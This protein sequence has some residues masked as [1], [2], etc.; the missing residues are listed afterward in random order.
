VDERKLSLDQEIEM[1]PR[2]VFSGVSDIAKR[3]PNPQKFR[4]AEMVELMVARSDNTAEETLFRIGGGGSEITARLRRWKIDGVRVDRSER[5]CA[6]DMNGVEHYP[7]PE[8]WTDAGIKRLI[9]AVP[10]PVR[11]KT[12]LKGLKDPRDT[13][14]PKGTVA[15]F[16][17]LFRGELLSR[18]SSAF[19]IDILKSTVSFPTR[20][21]GALPPGT[22][23][24]HKTGSHQN[25]TSFTA[26]T[27]DSGVIFL[28]NGGQL[29]VSVYV[30]GSTRND[31]E[32][33]SVIARAALAAF[34]EYKARNLH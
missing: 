9:D 3:W 28:P 11:Y 22:V 27:N 32:R 10:T 34:E 20:L 6:L 5:Q 29:A 26:A 15:M 12:T 16:A 4:L 31:A 18:K 2:D 23:V 25:L 13:A 1:L 14:T 33:D 30:K 7:P 21:K 17:R 19:L 24:A 8:Q